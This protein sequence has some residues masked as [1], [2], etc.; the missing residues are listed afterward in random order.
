[1]SLSVFCAN[2][3]ADDSVDGYL[4]M[5]LCQKVAMESGTWD[6]D[7]YRA[8]MGDDDLDF[9]DDESPEEGD[10]AN[11]EVNQIINRAIDSFLNFLDEL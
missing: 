6:G 5:W 8:C 11:E 10:R 3:H 7:A 9:V 1:M 4:R 2:L